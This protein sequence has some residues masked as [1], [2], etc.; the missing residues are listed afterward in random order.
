MFINPPPG[1]PTSAYVSEDPDQAWSE[2]GPHLLH[3]ARS[4]AAWMENTTSASKSTAMTVDQLRS[5]NGAYRILTPDQAVEAIRT[6]GAFVT[7][8]LCGGIPPKT[9][10]KSLELLVERVLPRVAAK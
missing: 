8:P 10:W 2:I 7:K 3:D 6:Y 4:Y 1:F 5:E 9:A